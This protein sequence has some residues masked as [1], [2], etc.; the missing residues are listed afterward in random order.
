MI[1]SMD[2]NRYEDEGNSTDSDSDGIPQ[3]FFLAAFPDSHDRPHRLESIFIV[4]AIG[5]SGGENGNA[6]IRPNDN[7]TEA[8]KT[9][10]NKKPLTAEYI[11]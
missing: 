5:N 3:T 2:Y 9:N 1:R 8:H 6:V 4:G 11:L 7:D 10:S